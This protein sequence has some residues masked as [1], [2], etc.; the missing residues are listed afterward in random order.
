MCLEGQWQS[1]GRGVA[2]H[3]E[4]VAGENDPS[5]MWHW[6][7]RSNEA[8]CTMQL[9]AMHE[10][11]WSGMFAKAATTTGV[12]TRRVYGVPKG[13]YAVGSASQRVVTL[14]TRPV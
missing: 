7:G 6:A 10:F 2:V 13:Q 5:S 9:I 8:A 1:V 12:P 3:G 4:G 14:R 11:R